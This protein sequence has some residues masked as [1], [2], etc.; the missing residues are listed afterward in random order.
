MVDSMLQECAKMQRFRHPNVMPLIGVCLDG[1][2]TPLIVMPYMV[3]GSLLDYL[4]K[5]RTRLVHTPAGDSDAEERVGTQ[6]YMNLCFRHYVAQWVI[7][8]RPCVLPSALKIYNM[9]YYYTCFI[10]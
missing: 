8:P 9:H 10:L 4:R 6:K 2:P 3:N 7:F 5:E 1:G